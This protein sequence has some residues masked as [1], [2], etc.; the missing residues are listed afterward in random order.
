VVEKRRQEL[1]IMPLACSEASSR[2]MTA[3]FLSSL[4][5]SVSMT[6]WVVGAIAVASCSLRD[7]EPL[8]PAQGDQ[9]LGQIGFA[10]DRETTFCHML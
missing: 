7:V 6:N 10:D 9:F 5:F 2:C 1:T 8:S 4:P 3:R